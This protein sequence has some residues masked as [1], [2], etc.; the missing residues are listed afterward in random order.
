MDKVLVTHVDL[1]GV[2]CRVLG[3]LA[4][5]DELRVVHVRNPKDA[6]EALLGLEVAHDHVVFVTDISFDGAAVA[7]RGLNIR[8]FDHHATAVA[9]FAP[10]LWADVR[11]NKNGRPTCGAELFHAYLVAEGLIV[12]CPWVV[13]Q[14]RAYDTWAWANDGDRLPAELS[15]LCFALGFDK[16]VDAFEWRLKYGDLCEETVFSTEERTLL[17]FLRE[18]EEKEIKRYLAVAQSI[19]T[20]YGA[21]GFVFIGEGVNQSAL[22]NAILNEMSVEFAVMANPNTGKISARSRDGGVHVGKLMKQLFGDGAGGHACAGGAMLPSMS[23][24]AMAWVVQRRFVE[25]M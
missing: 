22:G 2:F 23:I 20:P 4:F 11:V 14:V 1:D 13:E 10:F 15:Q 21:M 8:L 19:P 17:D 24:D 12:P 6:T 16:F 18:Q 9:E 3:R 5:G 7:A 25:V